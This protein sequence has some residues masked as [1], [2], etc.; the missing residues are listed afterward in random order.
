M[1]FPNST[2]PQPVRIEVL[3][4]HK[5][6]RGAVFEPLPGDEIADYRNMHVVVSE[7]GAIRG[8]HF[9]VRGTE[10]TAVAGPTLVRFREGDLVR[11]VEVP[12]GEVWRFR[13]PPG[14]PH[15]FRNTGDRVAILAS[16][17][18]E[19]HD[20]DRPDAVREVLLEV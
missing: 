11:D 8:N 20:P 13:F 9:H 3:V 18:T 17:N 15:A 5:D 4:S 7:P 1:S 14:T 6:A 16:F 2:S 10:M 12:A 19:E